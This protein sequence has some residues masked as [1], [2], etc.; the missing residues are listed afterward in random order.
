M[1]SAG[2]TPL[3]KGLYG[4]EVVEKGGRSRLRAHHEEFTVPPR[5]GT[6]VQK[7]GGTTR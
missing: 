3:G 1:A 7:K 2:W 6:T 4:T 5:G